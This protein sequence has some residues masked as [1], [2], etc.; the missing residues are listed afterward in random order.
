M[1]YLL[2]EY[3]YPKFDPFVS[4]NRLFIIKPPKFIRDL[5]LQIKCENKRISRK[6][7]LTIPR[8]KINGGKLL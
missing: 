7:L 3:N 1:N 6:I 5:E 4:G 8:I 2:N